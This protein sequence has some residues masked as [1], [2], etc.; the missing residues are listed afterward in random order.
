MFKKIS[1]I[2]HELKIILASLVIAN[3]LML[4]GMNPLEFT[5]F[6]GSKIGR[7][8]GISSSV[9][10]NPYNTIALQLKEKEARLDEKDA[11][12]KSRE[13][14]LNKQII[15]QRTIIYALAGMVGLLF[16]LVLF[17]FYLDSKRKK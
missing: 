11:E 4:A 3:L 12:L 13:A 5:S 15:S 1:K 8:I 6:V 2:G 17:N 16:M 14:Q 10:E 9:P 7:A